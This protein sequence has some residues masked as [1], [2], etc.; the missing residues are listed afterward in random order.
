MFLNLLNWYLTKLKRNNK[1]FR[2]FC[3]KF[4]SKNLVETKNSIFEKISRPVDIMNKLVF[5]HQNQ[6][7]LETN[8]I[9]MSQCN[10]AVS[11]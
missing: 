11:E 1:K 3:F 8:Y 6:V 4:F 5:Y 2:C 7:F 10:Y 9:D